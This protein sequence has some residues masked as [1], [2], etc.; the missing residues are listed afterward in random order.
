MHEIDIYE[1]TTIMTSPLPWLYYAYNSR[2][3]GM[4]FSPEW[5]KLDS[6]ESEL[7]GTMYYRNQLGFFAQMTVQEWM[8]DG[9]TLISKEGAEYHEQET[10]DF[11]DSL[12]H[13]LEL[14]KAFVCMFIHADRKDREAVED[15]SHE[16]NKYCIIQRLPYR[17][18]LSPNKENVQPF[19]KSA[20]SSHYNQVL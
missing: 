5:N 9:M 4:L 12:A 15:W 20:C 11:L 1:E 13:H 10:V 2:V 18:S 16:F 19:V 17:A 3:V 14:Y 6:G 7:H 8:L